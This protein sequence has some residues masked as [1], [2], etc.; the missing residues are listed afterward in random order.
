MKC[1]AKG[2]YDA[3]FDLVPEPIGID[4][5]TAVVCASDPPHVDLATRRID[6][7]LRRYRDII[8][9]L[10]IVHQAHAAAD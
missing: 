9:G 6:R 4:H 5:K 1:P 8:L 2:L 10:L 3:T 7:H